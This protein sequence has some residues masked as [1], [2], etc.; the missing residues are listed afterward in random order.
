MALPSPSPSAQAG[1]VS[2][3]PPTKTVHVPFTWRSRP[4]ACSTPAPNTRSAPGPS[5]SDPTTPTPSRPGDNGDC[6]GIPEDVESVQLNVTALRDR[7]TFLTVWAN[8]DRPNGSSLN[9]VAGEPPTPNAVTVGLEHRVVRGLQL[10]RKRP[11]RSSTSTATIR[12]PARRPLLQQGV[13]RLGDRRGSGTASGAL[14]DGSSDGVS[15]EATATGVDCVLCRRP[16]PRGFQATAG[17]AGW[18]AAVDRG[19]AGDDCSGVTV[20]DGQSAVAVVLSDDTTPPPAAAHVPRPATGTEPAPATDGRPHLRSRELPG[21]RRPGTSPAVAPTSSYDLARKPSS[22]SVKRRSSSSSR[23]G[24]RPGRG[25]RRRSRTPPRGRAATSSRSRRSDASFRSLRPFCDGRHQ[26]AL[27]AEV[28]VDLGEFEPVGRGDQCLDARVAAVGRVVLLGDEPARR[29]VLPAADAAAELME[30]GDAESVGVE[31][32]HHRR[33]RHVDAD[34]DHRGG[35]EHV[36]LPGAEQIHRHLLLRRCQPAVQQPDPETLELA[37]APIA[38]TSPR[39]R[40]PRASRSRRS[41]GRRRTPD[42]PRSPRGGRRPTPRPR[43][44]GRSPTW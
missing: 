44:A 29:G 12:P 36:E 41:A 2:S 11:P 38:G 8:G 24:D 32:H 3:T 19:D 43:A 28:E 26:G 25:R 6:T 1:S 7:P 18:T 13:G 16:A 22:S 17:A 21:Q 34:L 37:R 10:R 15:V 33:V 39:R 27:A 30:L 31:D 35:D 42:D 4:A 5:R 14:A 9:P 20:Q 23:S 40:R